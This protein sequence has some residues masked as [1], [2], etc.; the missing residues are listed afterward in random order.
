VLVLEQKIPSVRALQ[1]VRQALLHKD[2]SGELWFVVNRYDPRVTGFSTDELKKL[3][4]VP[5]LLTVAL[6]PG[7]VAAANGG[8]TL[9]QAAPGGRGSADINAL[10]RRL[11]PARTAARPGSASGVFGRMVR[12]FGLTEK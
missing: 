12:A 2:A 10:A 3:L 11:F 7:F 8:Q 5:E 9:R 1:M 4:H 6:D